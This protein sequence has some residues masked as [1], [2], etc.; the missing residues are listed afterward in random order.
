M[1]KIITPF[2]LNEYTS[3]LTDIY[4]ELENDVFNRMAQLLKDNEGIEAKE[5]IRWQVEKLQQL[6]LFNQENID[7]LIEI[8]GL[9]REEVLRLFNEVGYD[10]IYT[11]DQQLKML[12]KNPMGITTDI[13]SI[14]AA[15]VN[16][17]FEDLDNY[18]NLSLIN[19]AQYEGSA[20]E[21]AK[22]VIEQ[23]TAKA[24]VGNVTI[25]QA[26]AATIITFREKGLP[27]SFVDKGG[28]RWGIQRYADAAIRTTVNNAFNQ[29]T[30][31]RMN[32][33]NIHLV[34][35]DYYEGARPTCARIQGGVCSYRRPEQNTEGYPSIYEFKYKEPDGIRGIHCRHRLTAFAPELST[36]NNDGAPTV[37]EAN[38]RYKLEQKQ[39][40]Y[41]SKVRQAKSNLELAQVIGDEVQINKQKQL[42]RTRQA[43]LRD[44]VEENGLIRRYDKEQVI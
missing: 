32:E 14:L 41:E 36:N 8:S 10:T 29:L 9:A 40:Y 21:T 39:R 38:D 15:Y 6:R 24:L 16:Q 5:A 35:V 2:Q 44:F 1:P 34:R 37:T 13:D 3:Q 28:N 30:E 17:T 11:V 18:V 4:F 22:R 19:S 33:Y 26:L 42:I 43:V 20:I 12:N 31:D 25:N 27:S 7:Q 23:T